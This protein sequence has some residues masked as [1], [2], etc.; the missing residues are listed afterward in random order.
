ML[1]DQGVSISVENYSYH[2][3]IMVMLLLTEGGVERV[4]LAK[5]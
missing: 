2:E 4:E 1:L 3:H 5:A